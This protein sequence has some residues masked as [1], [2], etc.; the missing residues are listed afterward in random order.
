MGDER[1][2]P[3]SRDGVGAD[4][5]WKLN[6]Y[7]TGFFDDAPAGIHDAPNDFDC[8]VEDLTQMADT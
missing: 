2:W 4:W 3:L 1:S 8:D 7:E 5:Q 6:N